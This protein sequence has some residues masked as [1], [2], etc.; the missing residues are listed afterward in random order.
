MEYPVKGG[1]LINK[2]YIMAKQIIFSDEAREKMIAGMQIV[3]KTVTTTM[4]PK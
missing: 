2:L 3:A 1:I 4:G